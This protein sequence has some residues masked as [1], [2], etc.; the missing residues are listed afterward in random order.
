MPLLSRGDF[1]QDPDA[2]L[3]ASLQQLVNELARDASRHRIIVLC[4]RAGKSAVMTEILRQMAL[5]THKPASKN[6]TRF[7]RGGATVPCP[8]GRESGPETFTV[9]TKGETEKPASCG[10]FELFLEPQDPITAKRMR[11]IHELLCKK[12][13]AHMQSRHMQSG[14]ASVSTAKP[15]TDLKPRHV[16]DR[17]RINDILAAMTM[18]N[19][20]DKAIPEEWMDELSDLVWRERDRLGANTE[21]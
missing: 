16:V 4:R 13:E 10:K 17:L 9:V 15:S 7:A 2:P 19:A 18:R 6:E 14:L 20:A 11:E 1:T 8:W 3:P 12:L 21:D 5:K